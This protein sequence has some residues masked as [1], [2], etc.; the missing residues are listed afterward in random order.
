MQIQSVLFNKKVYNRSSAK[1]WLVKHNFNA[2]YHDKKQSPRETKNYLRYR[3]HD[4]NDYKDNT[5]RLVDITN[6]VKL[7]VGRR[8]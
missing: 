3:Q 5:F 8:L 7:V 4:P 2:H 6:H 1:M